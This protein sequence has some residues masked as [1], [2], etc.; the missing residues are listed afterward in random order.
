MFSCDCDAARARAR[1][2]SSAPSSS[3]SSPSPP[4][5]V[6][7]QDARARATRDISYIT[8]RTSID[9]RARSMYVRRRHARRGLSVRAR[10][11]RVFESSDDW[12]SHTP[13]GEGIL[14]VTTH[15]IPP[16]PPPDA[17]RARATSTDDVARASGTSHRIARRASRTTDAHLISTRFSL[18]NMAPQRL[19]EP[20]LDENDNRCATR[21][22]ASFKRI[23]AFASV[24]T[25]W[26]NG[27]LVTSAC[28]GDDWRERREMSDE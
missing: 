7:R 4:R 20:L 25:E 13:P 22:R 17:T 12:S 27:A 15:R 28:E 14:L 10:T 18:T 21:A 9:A 5:I 2:K 3:S 19:P 8:L 11:H 26:R 16:S 1:P 23:V 24:Q 6:T